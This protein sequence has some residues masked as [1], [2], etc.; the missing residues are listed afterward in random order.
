MSRCGA[1][2]YGK[3]DAPTFPGFIWP[4]A[5]IRAKN[6]HHKPQGVPMLPQQSQL[7]GLIPLLWDNQQTKQIASRANDR[8]GQIPCHDS[9]FE[10]PQTNNERDQTLK[11]TFLASTSSECRKKRFNQ[12]SPKVLRLSSKY[13]HCSPF[14]LVNS[15][16]ALDKMVQQEKSKS[17][18]LA[19][20][21]PTE[22]YPVSPEAQS[23][24]GLIHGS[25]T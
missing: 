18:M 5:N 10:V 20:S 9:H 15:S 23:Y 22:E 25:P 21:K 6:Q 16:L 2:G 1:V 4:S 24:S 12:P 3:N 11:S 8:D 7:G 17:T 19:N 14:N 13:D